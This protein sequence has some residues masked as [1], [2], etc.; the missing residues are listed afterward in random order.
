MCACRRSIVTPH[1][2]IGLVALIVGVLLLAGNLGYY[3]ARDLLR[4]WPAALILI[5]VAKLLQ[6]HGLGNALGGTL[7]TLAGV[8]LLGNTLNVIRMEFWE[9]VW[10]FWPVALVVI[11]LSTV[12]RTLRRGTG[13]ESR[14]DP[15]DDVH[16]VAVLGGNKRATG[17]QSFRGGELTVVLGGVELDLTRAKIAGNEA[18]LDVFTMWG[19]LELRIPDGWVV[20]NQM[21]VVLG[22]FED[23]TRPVGDPHAPR[24]VLRGTTVMGG[25]EVKH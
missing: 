22:G 2:T 20:D 9:A 7:W 6:A 11:G 16:M 5:G 4:Y 12:L 19:G 10:T 25:V 13:P 24:L 21:V 15:R 18:A 14:L 23:R 8:W 1:L 17:S 3:P